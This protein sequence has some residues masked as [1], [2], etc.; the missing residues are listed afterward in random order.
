MFDDHEA[1]LAQIEAN[2]LDASA[3]SVY[4]DWL[5]EVGDDRAAYLRGQ[6]ELRRSPTPELKKRLRE[7]YPADNIPWVARLE[8]CGA[9]DANLTE[10][11]STWLTPFPLM[12]QGTVQIE[13]PRQLPRVPSEL[14]DGTWSWLGN[15]AT[16]RKDD[17][18]RFWVEFIR[19]TKERGYFIPQAIERFFGKR[20]LAAQYSPSFGAYS[21][22]PAAESFDWGEQGILLATFHQ[23][24]NVWGVM[25]PR[26]PATYVPVI[27]GT[28]LSFYPPDQIDPSIPADSELRDIFFVAPN[29]EEFLYRCQLEAA[30]MHKLAQ[31]RSTHLEPHERDYH[32]HLTTVTMATDS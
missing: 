14:F 31:G 11:C 29:L 2:P 19:Q 16:P 22:R 27:L 3:L 24:P 30:I 21:R 5:E 25:L 18:V 9:L 4:A 1:F 32:E 6:T 17:D 13:N 23:Y 28:E 7:L 15:K 10:F 12:D 8:Q 20:D 26:Q